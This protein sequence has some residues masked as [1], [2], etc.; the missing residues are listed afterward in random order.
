[1]DNKDRIIKRLRRE[2]RE[3]RARLTPAPPCKVLTVFD[4]ILMSQRREIDKVELARRRLASHPHA[5]G[6]LLSKEAET[7]RGWW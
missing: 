4:D 3:L 6:Q 7:G 2:N 1:M 5:F